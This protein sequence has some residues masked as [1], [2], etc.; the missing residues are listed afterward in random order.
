MISSRPGEARGRRGKGDLLALAPLAFVMAV[1]FAVPIVRT[2][3]RSVLEPDVGL[4]NFTKV[5]ADP[6]TQQVFWTTLRITVGVTLASVLLAY[7]VASFA[8]RCKPLTRNVIFALVLVPFWTSLLVRV[9]GWT[10]ILQRT[11]PLN[12]LLLATGIVP[13]PLKLLY[14]EGAVVLGITHYM[15]PFMI[16]SLYVSFRGI[17]PRLRSAAATMGAKP[18]RIFLT[19]TLPLTMPGLIAGSVLVFIGS[20]GFFVTPALLGSPSEMMIAN[21]ITFQVK[22]ALD[23][24]VA[25]TIAA[26]L[27]LAVAALSWIYFRFLD[28]GEAFA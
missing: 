14:T 2:L 18:L 27:V 19:I 10:F 5:L 22:E 4:E 7:P 28:R 13:R 16:F 6:L 23:W 12:E 8:A 1:L 3:M 11:G 17:D 15:L 26:V 21:L 24:P 9:Y 25:S 20:L